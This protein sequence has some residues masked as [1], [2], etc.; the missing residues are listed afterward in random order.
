[1]DACRSGEN[2]TY[3]TLAA[4]RAG[5]TEGEMRKKFTEAFGLWKQPLVL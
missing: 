1:V 5:A 3:K 4:A 2:V